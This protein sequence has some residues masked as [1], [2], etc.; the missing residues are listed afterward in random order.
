[1]AFRGSCGLKRSSSRF[2]RLTIA[3]TAPPVVAILLQSSLATTPQRFSDGKTPV[4]W[5]RGHPFRRQIIEWL[6]ARFQTASP[7]IPDQV[8]QTL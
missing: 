3:L 8:G 5:G 1:M 6:S 7:S 2:N 4:A